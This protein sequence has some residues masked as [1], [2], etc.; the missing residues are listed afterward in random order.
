MTQNHAAKYSAKVQ[1]SF[2]RNSLTDNAVNHDYDF[3]G[4]KTINVYSVDTATMN[5][6][7]TSGNTRYGSASDLGT[8]KQEMTLKQDR[9]FTFT[10][11]RMDDANSMGVLNP[12]SALQRQIE[13]VVIPEVDKYR[14][15]R[16]VNEKNEVVDAEAEGEKPYEDILNGVTALLDKNVPLQGTVAYISSEFYKK[17]RLDKSFIQASDIA[18]DALIK[19]QVG[20]IEG[21]PL[22]HVPTSYFPTSETSNTKGA[23]G[24]LS[25]L[26]S[27]KKVS[28]I[29]MNK[30][31][32][33]GAEKLADYKIHD[34]PPGINGWLVE[35]RV[36][37]DAFLLNKKK[38]SVYVCT[39][40]SE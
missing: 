11:D 32:V 13:T 3:I 9:S 23:L 4:V 7:T 6:Y 5:D 40:P 21:I 24:N 17:I 37:Y 34:N 25:S 14:L 30:T 10:I 12:G 2:K 28:F 22:V 38:D 33:L 26:L 16:V 20:M 19:G 15:A 1:E 36:V 39:T 8:T 35:G 31:A 29:L 27:S 18:Q